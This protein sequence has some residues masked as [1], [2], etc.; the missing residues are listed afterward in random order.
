MSPRKCARPDPGSA[1]AR[2]HGTVDGGSEAPVGRWISVSASGEATVA[3]DLAVLSF[4]VSASGAETSPLRAEVNTRSSAVLASLREGGVAEADLDAPDIN[5]EPQYD[6]RRGR[7]LV[8]YRVVRS[9]TARVRDLDRLGELL[10]GIAAAG[11]NEV[12]GARMAAS[13]PSAAEHAALE[14]AVARA[15]AKAEV[16]ARAAGV[17]LGAV[18]R[19]QEEGG[20]DGPPQPVLRMAA[21]E[22]AADAPTEVIAGDLHVTRQIRA[23]FEI[24]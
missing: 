20:W 23:W 2:A 12:H 9:M 4:A 22:S 7:R 8:G 5:I 10:D 18:A 19:V 15:R 6:Y 24:D 3:A 16:L 17:T 11:A 21:A 1:E 14:S 13:D